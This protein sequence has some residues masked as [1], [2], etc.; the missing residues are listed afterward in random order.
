MFHRLAKGI[1]IMVF[2]YMGGASGGWSPG[3]ILPSSQDRNMSEV[4]AVQHGKH[5]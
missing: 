3:K 2:V 1:Q 5:Q 4:E